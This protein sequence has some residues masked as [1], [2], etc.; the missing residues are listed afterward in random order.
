MLRVGVKCGWWW[1][2]GGIGVE[3]WQVEDEVAIY[4]TMRV[5]CVQCGST[6]GVGNT[7]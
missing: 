4:R 7:A 6:A 1:W 5:L 3:A 2:W